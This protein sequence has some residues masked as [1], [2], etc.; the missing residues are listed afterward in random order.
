ML[1]VERDRNAPL[2]GRAADAQV[3][4]PWTE[5]VVQ[6]LVGAAGGLD[7]V[8]MLLDV[9]NQPFGVLLQAEEVGFFTRLFHRAAAVRAAAVFELQF[10]PERFAGRAVPSLVF[11]L[12][13]VALIV[14]LLENLLHALDV[15]VVSR[16]DEI[17][18]INVHQLPQILDA[19]DN[20]IHILFR[21]DALFLRLA[22]N[23]LAMLVR[24]G[25]EI[26]VIACQLLEA[27][28]RVRRRGAV[29]VTDVQVAAGV[30]N[31]RSDVK[32]LLAR[33]THI[34]FLHV[35]LRETIK[36]RPSRIFCRGAENFPRCHPDLSLILRI[37]ARP[38]APYFSPKAFR[39]VML[40][41]HVPADV[42]AASHLPQLSLRIHPRYS[43]HHCRG[44]YSV[45]WAWLSRANF[46]CAADT[47]CSRS[48][49]RP[50]DFWQTV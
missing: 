41:S 39:R 2:D 19:R 29:G 30:V 27:R 44:Y 1:L 22:L 48:R 31:G 5:E 3:F 50:A 4:Q 14:Q 6:H 28:H 13:D 32:R 46:S 8:R 10:R 33:F 15:A 35:F 25:Q 38:A 7:E 36:N 12:V 9:L 34:F 49:N 21:R 20:L 16:A 37:T 26:D 24:A 42:P 11:R 47:R 18:V 17:A 40:R 23:L 45:I 43:F